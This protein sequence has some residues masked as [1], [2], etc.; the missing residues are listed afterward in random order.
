MTTLDSTF[1]FK[2]RPKPCPGDLR[3]SWR[4][5]SILLILRHSRGQRASFAKLHVLNDALRSESSRKKL[6]AILDGEVPVLAWR[7]RVEPAFSRALEF[8]VGEGFADWSASNN[9]AT[10]A[11]TNDG[12]AAADSVAKLGDVFLDELDFLKGPATRITESFVQQM[13]S[14]GKQLL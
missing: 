1:V 14:A 6:E 7:L 4:V 8:V 3:I 5:S 10:M 11:L 9:R 12:K 13:L 2:E